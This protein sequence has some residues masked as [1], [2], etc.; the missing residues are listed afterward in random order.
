MLTTHSPTPLNQSSHETPNQTNYHIISVNKTS[1]AN[2]F[3]FAAKTMQK[4]AKTLN[5]DVAKF[6]ENKK[7]PRKSKT[8][9][10]VE[11]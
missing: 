7:I 3:K 5:K 8:S 11:I 9:L 6:R 1:N 4:L 10:W 2:K